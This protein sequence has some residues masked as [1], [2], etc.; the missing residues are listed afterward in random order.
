M[1]VNVK[2]W[3]TGAFCKR[4]FVG[5]CPIDGVSCMTDFMKVADFEKVKTG[6]YPLSERLRDSVPVRMTGY[7]S[8]QSNLSRLR[9]Q[10]GKECPCIVGI[11]LYTLNI[12]E[13]VI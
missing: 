1:D 6:N 13:E 11:F 4:G 9:N 2:E 3:H 8:S 10:K 5:I 7:H 12:S